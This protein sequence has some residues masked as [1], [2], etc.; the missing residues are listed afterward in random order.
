MKRITAYLK[1]GF[2]VAV[3]FVIALVAINNRKNVV[4]VWFFKSYEQ[5]NV[6]WLMFITSAGSIVT[7]WLL[8]AT[9]GVW[10]DLKELARES[11]RKE[12]E[13]QQQELAKKLA[14]TEKRIDEKS[15]KADTRDE[16]TKE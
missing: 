15:K 8:T 2:I 14:D 7:W 1:L 4:D 16:D 9:F 5:I 11:E 10:R 3:V 12:K 6:L 13:Q